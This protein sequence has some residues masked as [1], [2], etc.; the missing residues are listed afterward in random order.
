MRKTRLVLGGIGLVTVLGAGVARAAPVELI[1]VGVMP[2]DASDGLSLSP[3][4]LEDGKTPHDRA[5]GWGSGIAY[6]GVG[7]LYLATPDRGPADGATSYIDRYYVLAIDVSPGAATPVSLRLV[8]A[9]T[10][11]NENGGLLVGTATAFDA[12][13][14]PASARF[15]AEAVRLS[16][17]GTFFVSDEYGPFLSEFGPGGERL[18][19]FALPDK[20]LITAPSGVAA[21]ELPPAN[22]KGRQGNRGMEGL[23]ISPD[24]STLFGLMQN[25]LI[26]DGALDAA[27]ARVGLSTRLLQLDR[28]SGA[29]RELVYVLDHPG[30]GLNEIVAVNDHQFLVIER[31]G[32]AGAK[33]ARKNIYSIDITGASDVSCVPALAQSGLPE[34]IVPVR[35][36]LLINLLDPAFGLAGASFPEKIEGLTF[37]PRLPDGR[38]TLLVTS[39]NDFAPTTP[40]RVFAFALDPTTLSYQP[41]IFTPG[42]KVALHGPHSALRPGK[43]GFVPAVVLG[44]ALLPVSSFDLPSLRLGGSPVLKLGGHTLCT[45]LDE[46]DDGHPDLL[47]AFDQATLKATPT[48]SGHSVELTGQT[49]TGTPLRARDHVRSGR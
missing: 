5:G 37:G 18:R 47:C 20:F 14:S 2:G 45:T 8:R 7:N 6:S 27:N 44:S 22:S 26:Q 49:S 16:G 32:A 24:G 17:T 41:Q 15:D 19:T 34:G 38:L 9:T 3:A 36:T 23:A 33:A 11:T 28:A 43:P 30:N 12:T 40:S 29:T 31:D 13:N 25:A 39:D 46:N 42:L 1:G 35:K 48:T 21:A 4:L 10:L